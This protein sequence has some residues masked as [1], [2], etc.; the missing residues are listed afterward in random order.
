MT[1]ITMSDITTAPPSP[2]PA[3]PSSVQAPSSS[4]SPPSAPAPGPP[5]DAPPP[6]LRLPLRGRA[7]EMARALAALEFGARGGCALVAVEG[8]PG[9]GKSRFLDECVSA[10][11]RLGFVTG[12]RCPVFGPAAPAVAD[13]TD[14][15]RLI[16]LDD[17]D[18][19]GEEASDTLL[20]RRHA[21]YGSRAVV[22]LVARRC[23]TGARSLDALVAGSSGHTERIT[24]DVLRPAAAHQVAADV[25][26]VPPSA[27]L[28]RV[29]NG[30]GGH[31]KLLVEL[32]WGM[33][34]EHTV[35]VGA[36]EA[37]LVEE[38]IPQRL[39]TLL[40]DM[41]QD[42]PDQCRHLLRVAAVLGRESTVDDLLPI[43]HMP[44]SALLLVL[45]RASTTGALA[46]GSTRISFPNELLW[47][48]IADSVPVT[49][50]QALRRQ[51]AAARPPCPPE[52]RPAPP[53]PEPAGPPDLNGQEHELVRLVAEGL[54]NKQIARRLAISP[55]TVNYHLKKL[56]RKA[57][58]NSRIALLREIAEGHPG[59]PGHPGDTPGTPR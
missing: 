12:H 9:S 13:A 25:L 31:P 34:E 23:G 35:Q 47:R 24:L 53:A 52:A 59:L 36:H 26:G 40:R 22:W 8:P 43:L 4:A 28:A 48:L 21:Q 58:V 30:A 50:R 38:R 32:L 49:L 54:T 44:P 29:L 57:G 45:D 10:A 41:L 15:P 3:P 14:R 18:F 16:V 17:A 6:P 46:V 27:P 2:V 51:V 19:L 42:Y 55:H 56:F 7:D 37:H 39:R 5:A 33:R 1:A 11:E 20:A